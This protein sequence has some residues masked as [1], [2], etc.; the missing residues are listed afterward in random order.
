MS[1]A[2]KNLILNLMRAAEGAPV[3]AAD[4]VTSAALF[5]IRENSVRVT[6][7][8]L[9]AAGMIESA[10]RGTYRLGP[11]AADL[12]EDVTRWRQAEERVCDWNGQWIVVSTGNL[13]RSDRTALRQRERALAMLGF[14]SLDSAL[15]VRPDNLVGHA[16]GARE[17]LRRLGL[18]SEAP[19]FTATD[20][21]PELDQHARTLWQGK[22]LSRGY[23]QTR[24]KLEDWLARADDLELEV[25]ARECYLLGNEAI[26]QMVFDPMLPAPLVNVEE[27]QAFSQALKDFDDTG[28]R[29]WRQLLPSLQGNN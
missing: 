14:R 1:L 22:V 11:R 10:G 5:G 28:H 7:V 4:A 19:V 26:R 3:T 27:R 17:R 18:E 24:K 9:A 15:H 12:A 25:A 29:I 2:P 16:A 21:D 13:G 20:F 8:R 23:T 6:L